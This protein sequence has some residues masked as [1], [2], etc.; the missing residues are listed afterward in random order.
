MHCSSD[1]SSS[2]V[3]SSLC[4]N[5]ADATDDTIIN[6]V[7]N[8][9]LQIFGQK[10]MGTIKQV[11]WVSKKMAKDEMLNK[12]ESNLKSMLTPLISIS[13]LGLSDHL[14]EKTSWMCQDIGHLTTEK[15][16]VFH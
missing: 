12:R 5:L 14:G 4:D 15:E 6:A 3:G 10:R 1:T 9:D 16:L 2:K 8:R 11:R 7:D 13:P